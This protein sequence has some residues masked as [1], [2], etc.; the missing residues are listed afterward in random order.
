M[1]CFRF[2]SGLP[3]FG[4]ATHKSLSGRVPL[5][6]AMAAMPTLPASEEF[7]MNDSSDLVS[8]ASAKAA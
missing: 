8:A 2:S 6:R 5:D 4:G 1:E 3:T 7:M